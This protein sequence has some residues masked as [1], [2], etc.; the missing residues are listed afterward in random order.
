MIRRR[1][2][3][4]RCFFMK[5]HRDMLLA[6]VAAVTLMGVYCVWLTSLHR[7]G[8]IFLLHSHHPMQVNR[9]QVKLKHRNKMRID[10]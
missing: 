7:R 6:D 1:C 3:M 9:M 10:V 4:S 2:V 8:Y 5:V